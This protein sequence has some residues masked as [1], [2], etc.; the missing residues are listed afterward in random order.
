MIPSRRGSRSSQRWCSPLSR[1]SPTVSRS[2]ESRLFDDHLA[3]L[4]IML[5]ADSFSREAMAN[6]RAL[7]RQTFDRRIRR[8]AL[9]WLALVD[10]SAVSFAMA[11]RSTAGCSLQA[12]PP[13]PR[14]GPWL[15]PGTACGHG[16]RGREAR[17]SG[18]RR[19]R[20]STDRRRRSWPAR[21]RRDRHDPHAQVAG[22]SRP[23]LKRKEPRRCRAPSTS[24]LPPR[25]DVVVEVAVRRPPGP[26]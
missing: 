22:A 10:G 25:L 1:R 7:A 12:V 20:R 24:R 21:I 4:E 26:S 6:E 19:C 8:G 11:E 2:G 18:A 17:A 23:T 13:C 3:G 9:Q 16:G 5:A 14:R 15:L